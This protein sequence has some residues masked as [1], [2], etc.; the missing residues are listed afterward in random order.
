MGEG[1]IIIQRMNGGGGE[2][3]IQRMNGGGGDNNT[4]NEWGRGR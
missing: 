2:I 3:I 4:K 1:E